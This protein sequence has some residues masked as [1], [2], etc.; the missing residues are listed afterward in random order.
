MIRRAAQRTANIAPRARPRAAGPAHIPRSGWSPLSLL[1]PAFPLRTKQAFSS[2]AFGAGVGGR[3]MCEEA[4]ADEVRHAV[5][6][7]S[8]NEEMMRESVR[9]FATEVLAPKV[10][11]SPCTPLRA[12]SYASSWSCDAAISLA[13]ALKVQRAACD[14][15]DSDA[16]LG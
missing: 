2:S 8:E 13:Q 5:T 3:G 12:E 1:S 16:V 15:E 11:P 9:R 10:L 14:N 7:F 4:A 6:T